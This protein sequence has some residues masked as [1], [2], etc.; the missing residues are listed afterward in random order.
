[1]PQIHQP[2]QVRRLLQRDPAW[3][4][5]ALG[6]LGPS[7]WPHTAWFQHDDELALILRAYHV[8]ILWASG[9]LAGLGDEVA[10][11]PRFSVQVRPESLPVLS[12][13]YRT[14]ALKRMWRMRL[15]RFRPA[16][17][18]GAERLSAKD[19]PDVTALYA[20]GETPEFFFGE[21]LATG[22]FY[23]YRDAGQLVAV[24]GTHIVEPAEGVATI[25]NVFTHPEYR[26][27]GLSAKVTSAVATD[28]G[29]LATVVALN[30][31]QSNEVA[32]RVYERLG[33]VRH[34]EFVEGVVERR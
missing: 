21:M 28:L 25:G 10:V 6:D 5:Y 34:C 9:T 8:P 4:A 2:D 12:Q 20:T 27:R 33:F 3:A 29:R 31:Y 32:L 1:M 17:L 19:L 30:V 24:A 13:H 14:E 18:A 15:D 7:L 11:V 22:V 16:S 26:G 23:G